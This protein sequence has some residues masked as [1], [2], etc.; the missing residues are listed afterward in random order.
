MRRATQ[1]LSSV[2]WACLLL[3]YG[4]VALGQSTDLA[5]ERKIGVKNSLES[6]SPTSP[7]TVYVTVG[8]AAVQSGPSEDTYPTSHLSRGAALQAYYRTAEGWLG[9]RPPE[10]SFS[11]VPAPDAYL[12]PGGRVIEIT[13]QNSVSWIGTEL[14]SAKQYRW[15]VKLNPGEQLG[16]LGEMTVKGDNNRDTLWYKVAPPAGEYRWIHEKAVS[17]EP[18]TNIDEVV[19]GAESP[20]TQVRQTAGA[21]K[22]ASQAAVVSASS[23]SQVQN[24]VQPADFTQDVFADGAVVYDGDYIEDQ[25]IDGEY[26]EGEYVVEDGYVVDDGYVD[27]LPVRSANSWAGWHMLELTDEGFRSPFL[28][29]RYRDSRARAA[30]DPLNYDPFDLSMAKRPNAAP[31]S[32]RSVVRQDLGITETRRNTPWRDPRALREKRLKGYPLD[33]LTSRADDRQDNASQLADNRTE[34]GESVTDLF[35]R[36]ASTTSRLAGVSNPNAGPSEERVGEAGSDSPRA[37]SSSLSTAHAR[38]EDRTDTWHGLSTQASESATAV[39]SQMSSVGAAE[40][41]QVKLVL[42]EMVVQP[43]QLWNLP[44]LI[45]QTQFLIEHGASPIERGQAR[46]LLERIEE[47]E[48]LASKSGYGSNVLL[49]SAG[50]PNAS[51]GTTPA[52]TAGYQTAATRTESGAYDATGWLVPVHAASPSQPSHAIT[53]DAGQIIAY[54]SGLPGMNLARYVNHPVGITGLRGYLPQLKANHIQAQRVVQLR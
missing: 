11:W 33:S 10:N 13:G 38:A 28:E 21:K 2:L 26:I 19:K 30:S 18:P 16:V 37:D 4:P 27:G 34:G 39:A 3:S 8:K 22:S 47:F 42:N 31:P 25:Y 43:M 46:L 32:M 44:P 36:L 24:D 40:L 7:Q 29:R 50:L 14:G 45:R 35:S 54:V 41:N 20:T 17:N 23:P 15:Q 6:I 1:Q 48:L 51:T 49:A 5:P 12:L 52:M 9:I 53:N